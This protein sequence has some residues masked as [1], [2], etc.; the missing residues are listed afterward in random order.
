VV[1]CTVVSLP[2]AWGQGHTQALPDMPGSVL[3]RRSTL[4]LQGCCLRPAALAVYK[5]AIHGHTTAA[6]SLVTPRY[7]ERP[8]EKPVLPRFS[9]ATTSSRVIAASSAASPA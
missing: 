1:L 3:L 4:R 8:R 7:L 2:H 5:N 9:I 6:C